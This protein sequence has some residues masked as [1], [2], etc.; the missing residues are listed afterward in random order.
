[1]S[2]DPTT[3]LEEL[4]C[5]VC[6]D[7]PGQLMQCANG[8]ICC[9]ECLQKLKLFNDMRCP[10]CR[11]RFGWSR[12]RALERIVNQMDICI[13]CDNPSCSFSCGINTID[14][15]RIFCDFRML[16]CPFTT[17]EANL[18]KQRDFFTHVESHGYAIN[19]DLHENKGSQVLNIYTSLCT[20]FLYFVLT[21]GKHIVA[22]HIKSNP[23]T[24]FCTVSANVIGHSRLFIRT[25]NFNP[26]SAEED[27]SLVLMQRRDNGTAPPIVHIT[28]TYFDSII[29]DSQMPNKFVVS[30]DN[31]LQA[32]KFKD[33]DFIDEGLRE[34][35]TMETFIGNRFIA[36]S[37]KFWNQNNAF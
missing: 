6:C 4:K 9:T 27:Q 5:V 2:I 1:M 18:L 21:V 20:P 26:R 30:E 24:G 13:P 35:Q 34:L 29:Q 15:H 22:L 32:T 14:S 33:V 8:H 36:M 7:V 16:K 23:K 12:N 10:C 28:K 19:L 25:W 11:T 3:L 31:P 37:F 17:C